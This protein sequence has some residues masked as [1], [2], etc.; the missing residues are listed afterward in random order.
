MKIV[1]ISDNFFFL[2]SF[3]T[4]I[5]SSQTVMSED[6]FIVSSKSYDGAIVIIS[7]A[8]KDVML[9]ILGEVMKMN[10][11]KIFLEPL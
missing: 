7:I 5:K 3:P 6:A 10:V 2:N 11:L 4:T 8:N 1:V 9:K